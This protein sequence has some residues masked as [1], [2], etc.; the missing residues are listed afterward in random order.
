M[1][2]TGSM[3]DVDDLFSP[4]TEQWTPLSRR[5]LTQQRVAT[6]LGWT[7]MG[8]IVTVPLWIAHALA[9]IPILW[10]ALATVAA[11]AMLVWRFLRQPK[12]F[13]AWGFAERDTDLYIRSGV[14]T[15]QLTVVPYGR[16]QAVEVT[17]GPLERAFRIASV[18]LVTASA[19]SDAVIPGLDP[20]DAALLRDRLTERGEMQAAGL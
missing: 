11:L 7:I 6:A 20:D 1:G 12:I 2:K 5:Y 8:L 13:H 19:Q 14:W 15:R 16:M 18:K 17:S 3:K 4:P 9:D 10:P